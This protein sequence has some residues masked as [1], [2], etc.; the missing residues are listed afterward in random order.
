MIGKGKKICNILKDIRKKIA[1]D[2]NIEYNPK[3]CTHKGECMGT[4]PAC[5]QEVRYIENELFKLK[6]ANKTIILA[7]A[8][9]LTLSSMTSC[10]SRPFQVVGKAPGE[11]PQVEDSIIEIELEG[12]VAMPI[13]EDTTEVNQTNNQEGKKE[14]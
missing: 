4:C 6:M 13:N 12:E 11:K 10:N 9:A 5:E 8:A 2:N 7:G 14:D 3:E 1:N